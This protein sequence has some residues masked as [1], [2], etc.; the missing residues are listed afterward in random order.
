MAIQTLAMQR[1]AE[2]PVRKALTSGGFSKFSAPHAERTARDKEKS[3]VL[4]PKT[5]DQLNEASR[6]MDIAKL[7]QGIMWINK[8][9]SSLALT[10]YPSLSMFAIFNS[11]LYLGKTQLH[12]TMAL[13]A[14]VENRQDE[15]ELLLN[16]TVDELER[17][18]GPSHPAVATVLQDL[19]R[20]QSKTDSEER[21]FTKIEKLYR[22]CVACTGEETWEVAFGCS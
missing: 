17:W 6:L 5:S 9:W 1:L 2:I 19:A 13:L 18:Y 7:E 15:G 8:A 11:L 14:V 3:L 20:Y 12:H 21:D 16:K 10:G 22:R 4:V